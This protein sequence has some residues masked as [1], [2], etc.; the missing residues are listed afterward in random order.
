MARS[1]KRPRAYAAAARM[2][3]RAREIRQKVRTLR[4][5]GYT[6]AQISAKTGLHPTSPYLA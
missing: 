1:Y 5:S 4:R 3:K 6:D 2:Q